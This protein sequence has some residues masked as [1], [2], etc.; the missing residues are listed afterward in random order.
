MEQRAGSSKASPSPS[1]SATLP[2]LSE[3]HHPPST[4]VPGGYQSV[5]DP[6]LSPTRSRHYARN[7]YAENDDDAV[8]SSIGTDPLTTPPGQ[9]YVSMEP[10][11]SGAT[12][13]AAHVPLLPSDSLTGPVPWGL[14]SS[15]IG[16]DTGRKGA[17]KKRK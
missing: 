7:S 8:S 15:N 13:S 3:T 2:T 10:D 1:H 4:S 9:G 5:V 6:T 17:G 11:W 16:A 12:S 14:N